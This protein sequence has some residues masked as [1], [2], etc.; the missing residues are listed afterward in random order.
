[1]H[2]LPFVAGDDLDVHFVIVIFE[3]EGAVTCACDGAGPHRGTDASVED[4][5]IPGRDLCS[6]DGRCGLA[7]RDLELQ[8]FTTDGYVGS[9]VQL[10]VRR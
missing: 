9:G 4:V 1:M 7:S 8:A 5:L 2:A 10:G 3:E 6:E